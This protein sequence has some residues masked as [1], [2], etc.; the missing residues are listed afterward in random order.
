MSPPSCRPTTLRGRIRGWVQCVL[1]QGRLGAETLADRS[2]STRTSN[3]YMQSLVWKE[4]E[5][6]HLKGPS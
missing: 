3:C 4:P 2:L 1:G 6:V 5:L